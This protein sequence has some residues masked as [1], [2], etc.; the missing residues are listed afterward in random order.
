MPAI[1]LSELTEMTGG[2][3]RLAQMPPVG[4]EH[5]PVGAIVTEL[6]DVQLGDL[7]WPLASLAGG[8]QFS[9]EAAFARGASGAVVSGR[10]VEPW[11]GT[12]VIET[13]DPALALWQLAGALRPRIETPLIAITG[14]LGKTTAAELLRAVLGE[15]GAS[16]LKTR[17]RHDR[18]GA[19]LNLLQ[20][21][22][23]DAP[24]VIEVDG[25][26]SDDLTPLARLLRPDAVI[27]TTS[28][29]PQINCC[30]DSVGT[31][32]HIDDL[33]SSVNTNG[34]LVL[35]GDEPQLRQLSAGSHAE[36]VW[37]GQ[38]PQCEFVADEVG[39]DHGRLHFRIEQTTINTRLFGRH[40]LHSVLA[41]YAAGRIFDRP[42]REVIEAIE[43][44]KP[45]PGRCNAAVAG[46]LTIVDDTTHAGPASVVAASRALR[47]FRGE[48]RKLVAM[49]DADCDGVAAPRIH[50]QVGEEIVNLAK[51]NLL[52]V[53]GSSQ[54]H[55]AAGAR[56]AGMPNCNIY[57][58]ENSLELIPAL[59]EMVR[60]K[61]VVLVKGWPSSEMQFI[62][63]ALKQQNVSAAA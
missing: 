38:N 63:Q 50:G 61:D 53:C 51:P 52:F 30:T 16:K 9:V 5:E 47:E 7:Y 58:A 33:S 44:F 12:F 41:A 57:K 56:R 60:A 8:S 36:T 59:F 39:C 15:P 25:N 1:C 45:L 23:N 17:S 26:G 40:Q 24:A 43:A 14:S 3:L 20:S 27:V 46:E 22:G 31:A 35:N 62:V 37:F 29:D 21:S 42:K 11:P 32:R 28:I 34:K 55:I 2:R 49:G 54:E 13:D 19:C 10:R 18:S 4:G 48:G 6:D